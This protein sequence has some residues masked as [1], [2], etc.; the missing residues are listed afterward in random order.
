MHYLRF[1]VVVEIMLYLIALLVHDAI[2]VSHPTILLND[3]LG[4]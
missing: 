3:W 4:D 2:K 1:E